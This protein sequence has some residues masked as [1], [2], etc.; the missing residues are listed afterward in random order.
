MI[1]NQE[2]L[3]KNVKIKKKNM[4]IIKRQFK[5]ELKQKNQKEKNKIE[6]YI[7]YLDIL[8]LMKSFMLI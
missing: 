8:N 4:I 3:M 5:K 6:Y 1:L 7:K 2:D